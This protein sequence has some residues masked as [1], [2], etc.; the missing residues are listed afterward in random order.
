V[1]PKREHA[2]NNGQTYFVSSGTPEKRSLFQVD[3]Y[4]EL[5]VKNLYDYRRRGYLLHEFVL[6]KDHFHLLIT[7]IESLEKAVQFVK[8]G[9]SYKVKKQ[10]GTDS[11]FWQKGFD[12]HRIRDPRDYNIHKIYLHNNPVK[13]GY[14][15]S[16]A[17]Y[18]Y[19][20]ARAGYDLDEV[21]QR[22]KPLPEPTSGAFE[23]AP[24]QSKGGTSACGDRNATGQSKGAVNTA[25]GYS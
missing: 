14:C 19:S 16:P 21:P 15:V 5:F 3:R 13:R 9:F 11:E 12:E 7:P 24:S 1:I 4:A 20:S 18:L 8:G 25:G 17:E 22:L 23:N 10:F 6:M 2:T